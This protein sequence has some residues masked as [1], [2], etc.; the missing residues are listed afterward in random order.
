MVGDRNK[1]LV[2]EPAPDALAGIRKRIGA[3]AA[4]SQCVRGRGPTAATFV[5]FERN[6]V[7]LDGA[8]AEGCGCYR[9]LN[10]FG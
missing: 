9:C 5:M 10:L 4:R 7:F 6:G 8:G 1:T 3:R 2:L